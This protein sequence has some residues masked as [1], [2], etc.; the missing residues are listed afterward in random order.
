[1]PATTATSPANRAH[2]GNG[3]KSANGNG[4]NGNGHSHSGRNAPNGHS[5]G[6]A[7]PHNRCAAEIELLT[8]Q[9]EA[10]RTEAKQRYEEADRLEQQLID[11]VGVGGFVALSDGRAVRVNH[12]FIDRNGQPKV[13]AFTV[14]GVK[15]LEVEVK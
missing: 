10:K 5:N 1:M 14:A 6:N 2:R 9:W 12:N 13:K 3:S 4:R 8:Q 7:K 15:L 11:A